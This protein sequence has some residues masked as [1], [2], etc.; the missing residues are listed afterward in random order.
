MKYKS[1]CPVFLAALPFTTIRLLSLRLKGT[2]SRLMYCASSK[3]CTLSPKYLFCLLCRIGQSNLVSHGKDRPFR[4]PFLLAP[5]S[6]PFLD[7]KIL[8]HVFLGIKLPALSFSAFCTL[9]ARIPPGPPP[10]RLLPSRTF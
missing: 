4:V 8:R 7:R 10:P 1:F 6:L 3:S 9:P 2:I 5:A